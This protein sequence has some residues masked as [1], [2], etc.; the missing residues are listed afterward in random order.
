MSKI[1][2]T[3]ITINP[4]AGCDRY[5]KGC[6]NCYAI[7]MSARHSG[8]EYNKALNKY[9]GVVTHRNGRL[10]WTGHVNFLLQILENEVS[11]LNKPQIIFVNSMSDWLHM[12]ITDKQVDWYIDF[13]TQNPEHVFQFL[14]KRSERLSKLTQTFPDNMWCGVSVCD[15]KSLHMIDELR[16]SNAKVK[17]LSFEP[18]IEDLGKINLKG[19]DWVIVG[20]ESGAKARPMDEQW[21]RS[22]RDQCIRAGVPLS[23]KQW[24]SCAKRRVRFKGQNGKKDFIRTIEMEPVI[25]NQYWQQFPTNHPAVLN[26]RIEVLK[27]YDLPMLLTGNYVL[28]DVL[29]HIDHYGIGTD[30][31]KW[32]R[33]ELFQLVLTFKGDVLEVLL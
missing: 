6:D 33:D 10:D 32:D 27:D 23:F 31:K 19:I 21:V 20:G 4:Q 7:G 8:M 16:N 13:V 17:F 18:L 29:D 15:K 2:W 9:T 30:A 28:Q 5:T 3:D 22:I 24:G 11:K 1:K 12:K 26:K 25:D 14:S